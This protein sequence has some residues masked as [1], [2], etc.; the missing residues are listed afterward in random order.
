MRKT[1]RSV[2]TLAVGGLALAMA[3]TSAAAV[4][5]VA[6]FV[7]APSGGSPY[8][9]T[10]MLTVGEQVS[11]PDG[12]NYQLVGI[13]DGTGA[14]DNGN[15]TFTLYVNHEL[16]SPTRSEPYVG[17]PLNRGAIV[18]R[19]VVEDDG[20]VV[21][22]ERAYDWVYQDNK[23]LGPAP[24][25]DNGVSAFT[26]FCSATLGGVATGFDRTIFLTNEESGGTAADDATTFDG[27]G[28]QSVAIFETDQGRWEA[29]A[30]SRLGH[31]AK[32]NT[33]PQPRD[34]DQTV[35]VPLEDGPSTPDSQLYLWVGEKNASAEASPL[36]RNGLIAGQLYVFASDEATG[37][38]DFVAE[39]GS[40]TGEWVKLSGAKNMSSIQLEAAADAAGAFEFVR[41]EDGSFGKADANDFFFDTTGSGHKHDA[42][43]FTNALGRLY[44]LELDRN[45]PLGTA[46]LNIVY[47]ADS[48]QNG[49]LDH[50]IAISPDNL[51]VSQNY[52]MVQ[53]DGTDESRAVMTSL[54][55]DGQIWRFELDADDDG[56]GQ[57]VDASSAVP[58]AE[59]DGAQS[60]WKTSGGV[61]VMPG[62][63]IWE[64]SGIID[65][66]A[67]LGSDTWVF[68]V[69]AHRTG[70]AATGWPPAGVT[71]PNTVEDGQ[72]LM[73]KPTSS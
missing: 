25:V 10:S 71:A 29:H 69:Q 51:D 35:I 65:A 7:K 61:Q 67:F 27:L 36:D 9:F 42:T 58:V 31:F 32:E 12:G 39:G 53:E 4:S 30:L 49:I 45:D 40:I 43:H 37:E 28:G 46:T 60:R 13:P 68:D 33:V 64:T 57:V 6:P 22:G 15:G 21:S 50:D 52:L 20:D 66:S 59:L 34:D 41:I 16:T 62:K 44:H 47:N 19:F 73:M 1:R 18:S 54:G 55:R 26:R 5:T 2:T 72:L 70:S 3:M 48:D 11:S 24:T 17:G 23:L 14:H 8:A 56:D 38:Q 63:G